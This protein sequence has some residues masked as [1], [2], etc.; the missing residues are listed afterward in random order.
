VHIAGWSE[1]YLLKG[2]QL[3]ALNDGEIT[4]GLQMGL[5]NRTKKLNGIQIGLWNS[6]QKRKLPIINWCFSKE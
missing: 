6:N 5:V 3:G 4:H 1:I 2:L